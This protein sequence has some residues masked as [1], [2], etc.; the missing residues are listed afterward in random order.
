MEGK[1][2]DNERL[3]EAFQ[4]VK[5]LFFPGWDK[6]NKWIVKDASSHG[7]LFNEDMTEFAERSGSK[8]PSPIGAMCYD[9]ART[10]TFYLIHENDSEL[11]SDLIHEICHD[12]AIGHG[13]NWK[14][15]M[16]KAWKT[17]IENDLSEIAEYIEED[18]EEWS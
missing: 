18:L 13:D 12:G 17:A 3:Q 11:Y 9:Y 10:I 2:M 1:A 7:A 8:K 14:S 15:K 16:K 5:Q 6:E 4:Y